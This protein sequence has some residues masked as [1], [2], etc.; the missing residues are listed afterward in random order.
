MGRLVL[1]IIIFLGLSSNVYAYRYWKCNGE[2][3]KWQSPPT[4][5]F[6]SIS[7]PQGNYYRNILEDEIDKLKNIGAG[8]TI[9][10]ISTGTHNFTQGGISHSNG[11]N[12]IF[13][14]I[15]DS[16]SNNLGF[17]KTRWSACF[18]RWFINSTSKLK[19]ADI[20]LRLDKIPNSSTRGRFFMDTQ[21]FHKSSDKYSFQSVFLHE[22]G[23]AL[24]QSLK[25]NHEQRWPNQT[26]RSHSPSNEHGNWNG[27]KFWAYPSSDY[28]VFLKDAYGSGESFYDF[29]ISPIR[30]DYSNPSAHNITRI[31]DNNRN[32]TVPR[33]GADANCLYTL[34]RDTYYYLEVTFLN[35]GSNYNHNGVNAKVYLSNNNYIDSADIAVS[36]PYIFNSTSRWPYTKKIRFNT[37]DNIGIYYIGAVVD[38]D[39]DYNEKYE[40]R[41]N[42]GANLCEVRIQ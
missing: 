30:M 13:F 1:T 34:S 37:G 40:G 3:T 12:E 18:K 4:F 29:S 31:L 15:R 7:F 19:E 24:G 41:T 32:P 16:G 27:G 14:N 36:N 20:A 17:T 8:S 9:S 11:I 26:M 23:H 25:N 6:D 42:G 5:Y 39:D 2:I 33:T 35:Q 38:Y 28:R 21:G 22:M 10:D